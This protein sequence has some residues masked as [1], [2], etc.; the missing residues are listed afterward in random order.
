MLL[1]DFINEDAK[2]YLCSKSFKKG[3]NSLTC[4]DGCIV[5][6]FYPD[7]KTI[8]CIHIIEDIAILYNQG[9]MR[10]FNREGFDVNT[11]DELF[12]N[13]FDEMKCKIEKLNKI[14]DLG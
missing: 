2:C 12:I 14:V 8:P 5:I 13:H 3:P 11:S 1:K 9:Y 4:G 6:C 10:F 7:T